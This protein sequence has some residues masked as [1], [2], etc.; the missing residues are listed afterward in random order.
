MRKPDLKPVKGWR[1][2][3][4][5]CD[6]QGNYVYDDYNSLPMVEKGVIKLIDEYY[7]KFVKK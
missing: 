4:I 5:L 1:Y 2:R 7:H 6:E 3:L